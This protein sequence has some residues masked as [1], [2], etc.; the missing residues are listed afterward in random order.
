MVSTKLKLRVFY[1]NV[2]DIQE[3]SFKGAV[4]VVRRCFS[5]QVFSKSVQHLQE[6]SCVGV[7]F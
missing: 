1:H 2:R 4:A 7:S 6:N 3:Q 5:K